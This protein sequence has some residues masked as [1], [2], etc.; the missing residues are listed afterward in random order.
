[1]AIGRIDSDELLE[2]RLLALDATAN[3]IVITDRDGLIVW[4]NRAF[5]RLTGFT[6]NEAVGRTPTILRSGEQEPRVYRD[7]WAT[8]RTWA[9]RRR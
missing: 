2:L 4:A 3:A 9:L 8:I 7:L 5:T 6:A 1:M